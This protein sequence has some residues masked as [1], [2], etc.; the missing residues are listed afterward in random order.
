MLISLKWLKQYLPE[1]VKEPKEIAERLSESLA[2][3][4]SI[5]N[6][7]EGLEN[8]VVGEVK[9]VEK[10]PKKE[11]L[12]VCIVNDGT[13]T[14]KIVCGAPN[15]VEGAFV[16]VCKPGGSVYNPG[17]KLGLQG[18]M[19]IE[20]RELAGVKSQGMICS[21]KELGLSDEHDGIWILP[22]NSIIGSNVVELITDTIFE[23]ENK[24][25]THRPD[26]FSHE[27][28]A[29][30]LSAIFKT[31]F[32]KVDAKTP[33]IPTQL[34]DLKVEVKD[35]ELCPRF[36]AIVVT[37]V[38]IQPSPI[39]LQLRLLSVGVRPISNIVDVTNFFMMDM[40]QPMHA[41]DYDKVGKKKLIV[42]HAEEGEKLKT[43]DGLE[44]K[45]SKDML[46]VADPNR[47]LSIAGIMG[48]ESSEI[49]EKTKTVV[50]E[51]ANWEMFN[52][53][54]TSRT[55]GIRTE[56][57]TRFEKGQDPNNTQEALERA[58]RLI[59][60][61][62]GGEIASEFVDIY[63]KKYESKKM[64]FDMNS[65]KRVLGIDMTKE[66]IVTI[67]EHL[68]IEVTGDEKLPKQLVSHSEGNKV[69][70]HIPTF[71]KD[72]NI[73]E[74]IVEEVGRIYGYEKI[75]ATLPARTIAAVAQ[76]P[77]RNFIKSVKGLMATHGFDE[78]YTYSFVGE[79]EY[80]LAGTDT[81][82]LIKI[83]N[84]LAP[85]LGFVRNSM[86]PT[87]IS[88]LALNLKNFDVVKFFEISRVSQKEKGKDGLPLQPFVLAGVVSTKT[89]RGDLYHHLKALIEELIRKFNIKDV[90]YT[91]LKNTPTKSGYFHPVRSAKVTAGE[92]VLGIIGELHPAI[93]STYEFLGSTA[94]FEFDIETLQSVSVAQNEYKPVSTM[95]RVER[96]ISFWVEER[97]E[98]GEIVEIAL[99]GKNPLVSDVFVKDI[100]TDK[101]KVGEKSIT[102][103]IKVQPEEKSLLDEE[104]SK[105]VDQIFKLITKKFKVK[106]RK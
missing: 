56:A 93:S 86:I 8:I 23:I 54:R 84:P 27:G 31:T 96:D 13:T 1:L 98:V 103:T 67:L 11:K 41:F 66:E 61:I 81:K 75:P 63:E 105:I 97:V 71:R 14:R 37:N 50:L 104:V 16:A 32:T 6:L 76:N 25:L 51:A 62:A 91:N 69:D 68:Q 18:V 65:V 89:K 94:I 39:W 88:K 70:L 33:L 64:I 83:S 106:A 20:E 28:I 53:R 101:K 59:S 73:T 80:K 74:D 95:Q 43:L 17:D 60:E 48:G 2:E 5:R 99:A 57:G 45:L 46:V 30:E 92:K 3:V 29:R 77:L 24:S 85:E 102:L 10:H 7:G 100:F 72:L 55:L 49:S 40:G 78:I 87:H 19:K 90:K 12:S 58:V 38:K 42:R 35:T 47:A 34:V 15:V 44:R 4:E 21:M 9:K 82:D 36:S 26:C 52:N 79:E 22:T